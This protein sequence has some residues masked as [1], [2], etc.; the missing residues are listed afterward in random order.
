[1]DYEVFSSPN[2]LT[3]SQLDIVK[4]KHLSILG[5]DVERNLKIPKWILYKD[6]VFLLWGVCCENRIIASNNQKTTHKNRPVRGFFSIVITEFDREDLKVP[7]DINYFR[8][9]YK[10]EVEPYWNQRVQ[11][12]NKTYGFIT[13]DF[14]YISAANNNYVSSLNTDIF[15]CKSFG[16]IDKEGVIAAALTMDN[17]SLLI[18]NDNIEQ[19]TNRRGAFMNCLTP[20]VGFGLYGVKQQ[21]PKCRKYV[22]SFTVTGV[23]SECKESEELEKYKVKKKEE[24]MDKQIKIELEEAKNKIA[25]LE[26]EVEIFNTKLKK[27]NLWVKIF[28]I[29]ST[30]LLIALLYVQDSF[31]LKLFVKRNIQPASENIQGNKSDSGIVQSQQEMFSF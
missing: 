6:T 29:V 30:I 19:A 13:G 3:K 24:E 20:S 28:V 7:F 9:L 10:K 26:S 17:V 5:D 2:N 1:M 18:D 27:K 16:E 21:C 11:H 14:N 22:S 4:S 8:E 15:Q 23:C 31:S 12:Q 25:E